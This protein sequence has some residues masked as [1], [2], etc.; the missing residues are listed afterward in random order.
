[1]QAAFSPGYRALIRAGNTVGNQAN[2]VSQ[3]WAVVC[4][5]S[6]GTFTPLKFERCVGHRRPT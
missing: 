4:F 6:L 1:M 5:S 3:C 2:N